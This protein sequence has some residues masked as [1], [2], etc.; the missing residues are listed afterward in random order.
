MSAT[1]VD[2]ALAFYDSYRA[3]FERYDAEAIV[4]HFTLPSFIVSDAS[5]VAFIA[6]TTPEGCAAGIN[7]ILDL[8][9]KIGVRSGRLLEFSVLELSAAMIVYTLNFAFHD[10]GGLALYDFR[11]VYTLAKTAS[12][13]RLAAISHNQVPRL[14]ACVKARV[15]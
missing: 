3:A 9:R 5:E 13:W 15:A 2:Q 14:I 8:H 4:D 12:G 6:Y 7:Q 1:A 11:G 10:A